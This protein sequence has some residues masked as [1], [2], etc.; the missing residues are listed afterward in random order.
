MMVLRSEI[1]RLDE[2]LTWLVRAAA[3]EITDMWI[4][5]SISTPHMFAFPIA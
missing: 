1:I 3:P 5:I 2:M 4:D